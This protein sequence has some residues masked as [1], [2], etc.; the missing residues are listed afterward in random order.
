MVRQEAGYR[1]GRKLVVSLTGD[2]GGPIQ[3]MTERRAFGLLRQSPLVIEK[4]VDAAIASIDGYDAKAEANF[5]AAIQLEEFR[6]REV[7]WDTWPSLIIGVVGSAVAI[8]FGA[9]P[10]GG[11]VAVFAL[12]RIATNIF[13]SAGLHDAA[14]KY[15]GTYVAQTGERLVV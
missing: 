7:R 12:S 8:G 11:A 6:R 4:N 13:R 2:N 5:D 15:E 1:L 3:V 9:I 14:R 10:L